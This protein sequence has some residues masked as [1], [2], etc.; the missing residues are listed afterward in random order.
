M[1][2]PQPRAPDTPTAGRSLGNRPA[3]PDPGASRSAHRPPTWWPRQDRRVRAADP[4]VAPT[5]L[6]QRR[7]RHLDTRSSSHTRTQ[8]WVA[9]N[10]Q[11]AEQGLDLP[12]GAAQA[13][14]APSQAPRPSYPNPP[15]Q[16]RPADPAADQ[17]AC[18]TTAE[19]QTHRERS[20][21]EPPAADLLGHPDRLHA[22]RRGTAQTPPRP[23]SRPREQPPPGHHRATTIDHYRYSERCRMSDPRP[24]VPRSNEVTASVR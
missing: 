16:P 6:W 5:P 11:A 2:V 1:A 18:R 9:T 19:N 22:S 20:E 12:V 17:P 21:P 8:P 24:T 23:A 14:H 10:P 15:R 7:G 3:R 4:G 13:S